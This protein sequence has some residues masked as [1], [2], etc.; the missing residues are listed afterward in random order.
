MEILGAHL[1]ELTD[2]RAILKSAH[3]RGVPIYVPAF[4]DSELGLDFATNNH[5]RDELGKPQL[6]FDPFLDLNSF[7]QRRMAMAPRIVYTIDVFQYSLCGVV[8]SI[9]GVNI[10]T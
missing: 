3:E 9:A 1:V 10:F 7:H 6:R 5:M 2:G 4:T 8:C